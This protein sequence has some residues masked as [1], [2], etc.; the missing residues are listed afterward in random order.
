MQT[1]GSPKAGFTIIASS[2]GVNA[3]GTHIISPVSVLSYV[4]NNNKN[5]EEATATDTAAAAAV[6]YRTRAV[7]DVSFLI[8]P[9]WTRRVLNVL[10]P[11]QKI[12]D[13]VLM[14]PA[15]L[16]HWIRSETTAGGLFFPRLALDTVSLTPSIRISK[17]DAARDSEV[18]GQ[19]SRASG[20]LDRAPPMVH[21]TAPSMQVDLDL[22]IFR[23]ELPPPLSRD[24]DEDADITLQPF[25]PTVWHAASYRAWAKMHT[26]FAPMLAEE[27]AAAAR[28]GARA[29]LVLFRRIM[30]AHFADFGL[31]FGDMWWKFG[32]NAMLKDSLYVVMR[33]M[34]M[35]MFIL[36]NNASNNQSSASAAAAAAALLPPLFDAVTLGASGQRV[37]AHCLVFRLGTEQMRRCPCHQVYYCSPACQRANWKVHRLM[38]ASAAAGKK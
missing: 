26:E 28:G 14:H 3:D 11:V 34:L 5:D 16:R 19:V 6:V 2:G 17:H 12:F 7:D 18:V 21:T 31:L 1:E 24:D 13:H 32:L 38:C 37:C 9:L 23:R 27:W 30:R 8:N 15:M 22:Y 35:D 25:D 29:V 20:V 36:Y 4:H 33:G 10:L